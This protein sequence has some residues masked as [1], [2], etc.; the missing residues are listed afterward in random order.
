[1]TPQFKKFP[2]NELRRIS[3][4]Y[5]LSPQEIGGKMDKIEVK[6][7]KTNELI[8][9]INNPRKNDSAVDIVANSIHEFGFKVPIVID[10]SNIVIAG[11]TRLKAAQKL[12]LEEVPVIIAEDLTPTQIKAFRIM[13]N[14]SSEYTEWDDKLLVQEM[15]DLIDLGLNLDLTG[16]SST[17]ISNLF[18]SQEETKE[19]DFDVNEALNKPKYEIKKGD[20]FKLGRHRLICGDSTTQDIKIL[21]NEQ[22]ADLVI[23]D[24]PFNIGY[25]SRG[26]KRNDWLKSY[27]TDN[28][29]VEIYKD[30]LRKCFIN[31]RSNLKEN[32]VYYI[33]SGWNSYHLNWESLQNVDMVPSACV[34]WDK[35]NPGMG[36]GDFRHQYELANIGIN[37]TENIEEETEAE[38]IFYG[39]LK[40]REKHNYNKKAFKSRSDLWLIK[41]D[42]TVKYIHPTQKPLKL[43]ERILKCSSLKGDIV[44]DIFGGSGWT[45]ITC[46]QME[47]ICYTCELD[48]K[49][50]SV[51]I[52]R[53]EKLTGL[54]AE[55]VE[56]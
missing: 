16:F 33:W 22:K 6:Y 39:F 18:D 26:R 7:I 54:K 4:I 3:L 30:F 20:I 34:I 29:D 50:C 13:D 37:S 17:E 11:H 28:K 49:F 55:R 25:M 31:I 14:K 53:W 12:K 2:L 38:F 36:W 19:D 47:R 5:S 56:K 8:P 21:M 51:I 45:L 44:L 32:G 23:T 52:E 42:A 1:L 41:R 9:Y 15:K 27:G 10:K 24:P 35:G 43:A 46:E 48:P 40:D